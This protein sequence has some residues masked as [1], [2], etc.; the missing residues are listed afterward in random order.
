MNAI[1]TPSGDSAVQ[2]ARL[3]ALRERM[4][5]LGADAFCLP[6]ADEYLGEYIPAHNERLRWLTGFTGSAGMAV[7]LRDSAAIFVD[8]RYTVQVRRQ[9]AAEHYRYEH[10]IETP[11]VDWLATQLQPGS[12]VLLDSRCCT[13]AWYRAAEKRFARAGGASAR[14][15]RMP[16]RTPR[17]CSRR[18][19]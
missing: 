1:A 19:P 3:Q 15:S 8:G 4:E 18:I 16:G 17:W 10:L 12:T 14:R 11:P 7:V 9:V 6:R 2:G 5:R 13:L